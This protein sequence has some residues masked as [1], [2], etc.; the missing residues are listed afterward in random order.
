MSPAPTDVILA[1]VRIIGRVQGVWF[2]ANT[3]RA[4]LAHGVAGW[5]RN[6]PDGSVEAVFEG[7]TGSVERV[8]AWCRTSDPPARVDAVDIEY[9][10]P[11]GHQGFSIH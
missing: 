9:G 10:T 7:P 5:V 11:E 1:R 6:R 4:A 2:R 8:L 3:Q